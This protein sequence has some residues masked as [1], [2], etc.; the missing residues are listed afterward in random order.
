MNRARKLTGVAFLVAGI[1]LMLPQAAGA[2]ATRSYA[3]AIHP[4]TTIHDPSTTIHHG[5]TTTIHHGTTTTIHHG[6]TT[7]VH[8]GTTTTVH[9]G[10]T[11]TVHHGTTSTSATV[12]G[13][14]VVPISTTIAATSTTAS[15][16]GVTVSPTTDNDGATVLATTATSTLPF[17][18]APSHTGVLFVLGLAL[19]LLGGLLVAASTGRLHGLHY[20]RS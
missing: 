18:G 20:R 8:H 14:T 7:T 2:A 17:T 19:L 16:L 9:H 5:T 10:T 15:V 4:T 6:T 13:T 12:L 1:L 3:P 11:T